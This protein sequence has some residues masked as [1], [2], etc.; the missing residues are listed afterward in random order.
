MEGGL[1]R[2]LLVLVGKGDLVRGADGLSGGQAENRRG[3]GEAWVNGLQAHGEGTL[4]I[5]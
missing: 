4:R 1:G 2:G 5:C 3:A